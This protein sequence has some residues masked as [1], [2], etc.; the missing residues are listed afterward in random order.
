MKGT[1][2]RIATV[3]GT[4]LLITALAQELEKPPE[5]RHWHG[6]VWGRVPYDFRAPSLKRLMD[7]YWNPYDSRIL[8]P[9]LYGV[10]WALNLRQVLERLRLY[11]QDVSERG[12]LVPTS[13]MKEVLGPYYDE[14]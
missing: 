13:S 11:R 3:V 12:F 1:V 5:L 2:S 4:A 8:M 10:G 7:R 9:T 14:E 6:T